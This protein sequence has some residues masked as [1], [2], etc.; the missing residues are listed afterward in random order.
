MST[1][2][3]FC[4]DVVDNGYVVKIKRDLAIPGQ[5]KAIFTSFQNGVMGGDAI[6]QMVKKSL[7]DNV[8]PAEEEKE[9]EIHVFTELPKAL[10]FIEENIK[11]KP[12]DRRG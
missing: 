2:I 3:H 8:S 5:V 12:E 6:E 10:I 4:L 7:P 9:N 1:K 11:E